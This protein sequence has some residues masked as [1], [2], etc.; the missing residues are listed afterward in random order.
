MPSRKNILT[1]RVI[2]ATKQGEKY[3]NNVVGMGS[4][5]QGIYGDTLMVLKI[6]AASMGLKNSTKRDT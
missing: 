2:C 1:F 5:L 4:R 3:L 6:S